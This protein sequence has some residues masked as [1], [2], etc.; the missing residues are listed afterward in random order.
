MRVRVKYSVGGKVRFISHLDLMRCFFRACMAGKIPVAVSKGYSPHL[1]LSFGPPLGVGISS[2]SEYVDIYLKR[3]CSLE[4]VKSKLQ[5]KLP[6]GVVVE[7]TV[8]ITEQAPSLIK[9]IKGASYLVAVPKDRL[10][11]LAGEFNGFLAKGEVIIERVSPKG[12]RNIDIRPFV[13]NLKLEDDSLEIDIAFN[14]GATIRPLEVLSFL[15][16]EIETE[17]LKQWPICRRLYLEGEIS[18]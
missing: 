10:N 3:E 13:N 6:R 11:A 12:K 18:G 1:K 17:K 16:P 8:I 7:D 14:N 9:G 15:C 2:S 5:Q 4:D